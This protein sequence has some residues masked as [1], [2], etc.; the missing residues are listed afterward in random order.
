[1]IYIIVFVLILLG[2]IPIAYLFCYINDD[3]KQINLNE[4]HIYHIPS[5]QLLQSLAK[6]HGTNTE[7]ERLAEYILLCAA[8]DS[9]GHCYP[10][11]LKQSKEDINKALSLLGVYGEINE[12]SKGPYPIF[13]INELGRELAANMTLE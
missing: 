1:M 5:S 7:T 9:G 4:Y 11:Q 12:N 6:T 13:T 2:I 8:R 3:D 10:N